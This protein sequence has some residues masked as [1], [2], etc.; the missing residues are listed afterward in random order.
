MP[1][2]EKRSALPDPLKVGWFFSFPIAALFAA[3]IMWEKTVW[4]TIAKKKG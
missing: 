1:T 3:R 2:V 4:T